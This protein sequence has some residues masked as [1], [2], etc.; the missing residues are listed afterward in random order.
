MK[1]WKHTLTV[2]FVF[3][4]LLF[5]PVSVTFAEEGY[6]EETEE[7]IPDSYYYPIESN[8]IEGWP[9]GPAIESASAV[10]MDMD[11]GTF[12]YSKN[13]AAKQ[14][15]AST[16]KILTT[17]LLVENCDLD[18]TIT[19]SEI[20]YDL[21]EGSSHLGIQP[22][23]EMTL[24]DAAYG[25][26]LESANDI[27]NG[28][29]EY[30]GGSLSG[31]ADMMN[32][33]AAELGCINTHFSNPH[34]LYSE[35]HYTCAYDM[36]LI[37]Q[38]AY[39]NPIFREI[40]GTTYYEIPETNMTDEIRYLTNHDKL[41]QSDSD[42]YRSWC[43]GGK[44]G[45]T[46]ACLNTL[47]TFGEQD[48]KRLVGVVFRVNGAGKAYLETTQIMEYGFNEFV[49][50]N[51]TTDL[52]DESFYEIMGLNYL[53]KASLYQSQVWKRQAVADCT[54]SVTMPLSISV[55]DMDY[56]ITATDK[57]LQK[58]INY[59]YNGW[60]T[61]TAQGTF[62]PFAAPA[63]MVFES[64]S[65]YLEQNQTVAAAAESGKIQMESLDDIKEWIA[66][67]YDT[68]SQVFIEY[69]Q[70]HTMVLIIVGAVLLAFL[71]IFIIVLIF[72]LTS[73]Y[74]IQRKRR[75]EERERQKREEEIEQM[76]TA[77]I[78][79]ELRAVMEEERRRKETELQQKAE[80]ERAAREAERMEQELHA[81]ENLLAELEAERQ[82]R[83]RN[84]MNN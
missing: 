19:F 41:I 70:E 25:I 11:T 71:V 51:I 38:A 61:G 67:I 83:L 82:E 7:P 39:S 15:P 55:E 76:T 5:V 81:T 42:Y 58:T 53:G 22:G 62:L 72:R 68:G 21:E 60:P 56:E 84:S 49:T 44:T 43:T 34:G 12:L 29:A 79:S 10:V 37:A 65:P 57:S 59:S 8:E 18:E 23:E 2:I 35:D 6:E 63:K 46:E 40:A 31:F 30:I 73:D 1:D 14:Y 9:Q 27:A 77:E 47:V 36:A 16:T 28:V 33:R 4:L 13:A 20:V 75:Q 78:E 17:L 74:R 52:S 80:A 3:C 50:K 48:G 24:R 64:T 66:G 69:A 26:M 32:E 54:A 45:Y